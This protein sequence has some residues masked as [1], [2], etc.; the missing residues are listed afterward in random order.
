MQVRTLTA[1]NQIGHAAGAA[2]F[3]AVVY[4]AVGL[5][6]AEAAARRAASAGLK[7]AKAKNSRLTQLIATPKGILKIDPACRSGR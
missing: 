6:E 4:R 2:G 7:M 5:L 1:I 3:S